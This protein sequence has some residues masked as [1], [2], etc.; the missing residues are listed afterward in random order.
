M[1]HD[2]GGVEVNFWKI[3]KALRR[4]QGKNR[5][6][7][8]TNTSSRVLIR[9]TTFD[10]LQYC[11]HVFTVLLLSRVVSR[12]LIFLEFTEAEALDNMIMIRDGHELK[13]ELG[14]LWEIGGSLVRVHQI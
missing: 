12:P 4:N 13:N 7:C 3:K 6:N 8:V 5:I 1:Y 10:F 9:N 11:C 14:S 2:Y